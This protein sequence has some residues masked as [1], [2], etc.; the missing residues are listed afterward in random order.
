MGAQAT[1]APE[2]PARAAREPLPTPL[3]AMYNEFFRPAGENRPTPGPAAT[4]IPPAPSTATQTEAERIQTGI[5]G[6]PITPGS[7]HPR[8]LG[9]GPS[10]SHRSRP[11]SRPSLSPRSTHNAGLPNLNGNQNYTDIASRGS[12]LQSGSSTPFSSN[13]PQVF[14][15]P[16]LSRQLHSAA[17]TAASAQGTEGGGREGEVDDESDDHALPAPVDQRRIAAEAAMRRLGLAVP[18]AKDPVKTPSFASSDP[19]GKGKAIEAPN[20]QHL[21]SLDDAPKYIPYLASA[22]PPP[23]PQIPARPWTDRNISI[24]GL[25]R[26][27]ADRLSEAGAARGLE[28]RLRVLRDVD[29]VIW[30][31]MGELTQVKSRWEAE[32]AEEVRVN[33]RH[34]DGH[35]DEGGS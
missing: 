22:L 19:K 33:L 2:A 6:G 18:S 9:A 20:N 15:S 26:D 16:G 5:W 4:A 31:L 32:D 34:G 29:E 1:G 8:P 30:G 28:D 3:Q 17:I 23:H 24:N 13:P 21:E 11:E 35:G 14:S 25:G 10:R 7:F 12:F 27:L